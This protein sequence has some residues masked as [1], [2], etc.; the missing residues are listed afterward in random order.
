MIQLSM[1]FASVAAAETKTK[2]SDH[3]IARD[4]PLIPK[5]FH[6]LPDRATVK[7]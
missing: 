4:G 7:H 3:T 1:R 6:T 5:I 2:R